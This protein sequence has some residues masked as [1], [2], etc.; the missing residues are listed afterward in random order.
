[1]AG[2][3]PCVRGR[4]AL[5]KGAGQ[6]PIAL[7]SGSFV[8]GPVLAPLSRYPSPNHDPS[9]CL[10]SLKLMQHPP[11]C[12]KKIARTVAEK[13]RLPKNAAKESVSLAA[14]RLETWPFPRVHP[15]DEG[16][17]CDGYSIRGIPTTTGVFVA[18][19]CQ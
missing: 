16:Q 1:M 13:Q 4:L 2:M 5:G 7:M 19:T 6:L 8:P 10:W 11:A 3:G 12:D 9:A 17:V 18:D 15:D 14:Q